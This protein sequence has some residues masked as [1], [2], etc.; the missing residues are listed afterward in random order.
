[1]GTSLKITRRRFLHGVGG[2]IVAGAAYAV[3]VEPSW[4]DVTERALA[5]PDLPR[6]FDGYR[7]AHLSDLHLGGG[8]PA[9]LLERAVRAATAFEP[10]LVV[11]TGDVVDDG[12]PDAPLADVTAVLGEC[13]GKDGV[14]CTL[15]NHDTTSFR[16]G[17]Q[18]CE[19]AVARLRAAI[20]GGGADLLRNRF[21]RVRRGRDALRVVGLGDL[22]SGDF[23]PATTR[24]HEPDGVTVA[25]SHNP[26][27]APELARRGAKII[28]SGHTHGG[29]VCV[30]FYG[31][32]WIPLRHPEYLAGRFDVGAAQLYVNRGLG[33]SHRV[34]FRARPE[35]TLLTLRRAN[36]PA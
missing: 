2:G 6:A 10:D 20:E 14:L 23:E 8:V 3:G 4:L 36:R 22:W 12:G 30:P 28:L 21:V 7:I 9:S 34:R 18:L 31:P 17:G 13:H 26:D 24:V 33:F 16:E 5:V 15:G 25:L 29:Q 1:M 32:P 35:T 27:T 11:V 19:H